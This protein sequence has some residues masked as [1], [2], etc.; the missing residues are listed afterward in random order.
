MKAFS[1]VERRAILQVAGIELRSLLRDKRAIFSAF[2]LPLILYPFLFLGQDRLERL[3]REGLSEREVTVVLASKGAAPDFVAALREE[4]EAHEPLVVVDAPAQLVADLDAEIQRGTSESAAH[5]LELF[6]GAV[7][8]GGE[9]LV[10]CLGHPDVPG[11]NLVRVHYDGADDLTNE[12]LR[13]LR[14]SVDALEERLS[15]ERLEELLGPDPA[16]GLRLESVD[17]ASE[18]QRSGLMLGRLLPL[19]AVIVLLSGGATAALAAFSGERESGT[20]ETLLVQ[21]LRAAV[22]VW[23][24]FVAV[25]AVSLI[26][27]AC[28]VASVWGSAAAG[29][30]TLPGATGDEALGAD[31]LRIALSSLVFLPAVLLLCAT[32]CLVSGRAKSFRE[33]QHLLLPLMLVALVPTAL[34]TQRDLELDYGLALLPLAGQGL[35]FRDALVGNLRFGPALVAFLAGLAWSTLALT[36]LASA[37]DAERLFGSPDAEREA[38]QR[39]LQSRRALAWGWAGA[40]VV[41]IA[42]GL[43]GFV[44]DL[45]PL[46]GGAAVLWIVLPLFAVLS[47]RATSRRSGTPVT[48]LLGLRF[49]APP[50]L[51]GALL[52]VPALGRLMEA[53]R[54]FQQ[55]VL[56]LPSAGDASALEASFQSLSTFAVLFVFAVT[57]AIC[58]ELFFRGALLSGLRKDLRPRAA[59][60]WQA[61][62]FAV[63]HASIYRLVPHLWLGFLFGL[64]R[65]RTR[66]IW[67]GVLLHFG[68]NA[69]IVT[70]IHPR[71][72]WLS[73]TD[74]NWSLA[75]ATLGLLLLATPRRRNVGEE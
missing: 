72:A 75:L 33:G 24:K 52:V 4:L 57:P 35:S 40:F 28:N 3:S 27:L 55:R 36:R 22:F 2:V 32:L 47:A 9:L 30:G 19:L 48:A 20:L 14:E 34:S 46:R 61:L 62:I 50:H 39:R 68:Y 5:E 64:T 1:A 60:A 17:V 74:S 65:L 71:P 45:D 56:P 44:S 63:A 69:W 25:L 21:P 31:P 12:A 15:A 41:Y 70:A 16:A 11:R 58:E 23:G 8:N 73:W 37:F 66:S 49:P 54:E 10:Q 29:L 7:A 59:L 51:L 18:E 67:P 38:A 6:E 42:G 26:T 13:R 43:I 53:F